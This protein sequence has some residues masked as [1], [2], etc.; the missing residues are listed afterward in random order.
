LLEPVSDSEEE[1]EDSQQ[2]NREKGAVKQTSDSV[3]QRMRRSC[4]GGRRLQQGHG[5][6][7]MLG[8]QASRKG[9]IRT[10]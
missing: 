10:G 2:Q 9:T 4:S 7:V 1:A 6:M 3:D 8:T 5:R